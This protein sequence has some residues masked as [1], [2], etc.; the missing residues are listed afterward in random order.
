MYRYLQ[1]FNTSLL[2]ASI[3]HAPIITPNAVNQ[4]V[5]TLATRCVYLRV[6]SLHYWHITGDCLPSIYNRDTLTT[7]DF[8]SCP[9]LSSESLQTLQSSSA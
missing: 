9:H 1:V 8:S 4:C 3:K 2:P 7:L 6:L 5:Q